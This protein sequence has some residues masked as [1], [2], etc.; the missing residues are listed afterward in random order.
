VLRRHTPRAASWFVAQ[1]LDPMLLK[2]LRPLVDKAP[3]EPGR[4]GD[5]GDRH[6]VGQ[7]E[8]DP[9]PPG[10]SRRDRGGALPCQQRLAVFCREGDRERSF[11][12]T[13]HRDPLIHKRHIPDRVA[14][15]TIVRQRSYRQFPAGLYPA[16]S[17]ASRLGN[18]TRFC[19]ATLS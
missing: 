13:W 15:P 1:S 5:M 10:A 16:C 12:A 11:P 7:Q 6:P 19:A 14:L 4:G 17:A 18:V 3:A 8:N 2:P 9:P